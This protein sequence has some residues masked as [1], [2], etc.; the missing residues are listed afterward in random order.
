MPEWIKRIAVVKVIVLTTIG[1]VF[2]VGMRR[3]SPPVQRAVRSLNRAVFNPM[4]MGSAG[5]PGAYASLVHHVGRTSGTDY[6]TP[7]GALPAEDGFVIALPYG[8]TADWLQNVL[9]AGTATIVHDGETFSVDRPTVVPMADVAESFS[10]S[11]QRIHRMFAIDQAMR[12]RHA[13]AVSA[14]PSTM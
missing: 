9:A 3:K 8:T 1:V 13:A 14:D 6:T 4:Q 7:I 10:E 11:D 2:V 12:V 5:S